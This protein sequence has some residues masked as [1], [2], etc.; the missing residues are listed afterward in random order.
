MNIFITG[1]NR[2]LGFHLAELSLAQGHRV[3]AGVRNP[4]QP[5]EGLQ[6]LTQQYP[7]QLVITELDVKNEA[8]VEQAAAAVREAFGHIDAV[9]NNAGI[10]LAREQKLE[11]L[12]LA[13]TEETFQVNLYGPIRVVK[14]MLPLMTGDGEMAIINISSEAGSFKNAYGGDY[15]YAVSKG[16]LNLFSEHVRR[17]VKDRGIRAYAVHPGWIRTDMGGEKAPGDPIETAQGLLAL[18]DGTNKAEGAG[19][20]IDHRGEAMPG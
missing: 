1:A 18:I 14:H 15:P 4:E 19:I 10:L 12:S 13:A 20:F 7:D 17:Y 9:V 8:T 11:E 2:G 3:A 6:K 16:A 5:G